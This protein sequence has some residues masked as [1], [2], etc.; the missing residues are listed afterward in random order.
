MECFDF[1]N[2]I[3]EVRYTLK[4]AKEG[5]KVAFIDDLKVYMSIDKFDFRI[6][7]LSQR[8]S[9]FWSLFW[10]PQGH[11][12]SEFVFSLAAPNWVVCGLAYFL[13]LSHSYVFPFWVNYSTVLITAVVFMM[14][15]CVSF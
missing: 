5:I 8:L 3:S 15:I 7:S 9:I 14:A 12:A 1:R 2:I 10:Q 6:P 4:L 13:V 11:I